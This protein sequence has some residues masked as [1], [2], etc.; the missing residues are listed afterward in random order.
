MSDVVA[1]ALELHIGIDVRQSLLRCVHFG[2]AALLRTEEQ[3]VHVRQLD[4]VEVEEKQ[5]ADTASS[6]HL[7]C[8]GADAT[9]ANNGNAESANLL[10]KRKKSSTV[11]NKQEKITPHNWAQFP[12]VSEPKDESKGFRC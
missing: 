8:D 11:Q 10:T 1:V 7:C 3:S 4:L 6:Q 2:H 5:L 9:Q 12:F